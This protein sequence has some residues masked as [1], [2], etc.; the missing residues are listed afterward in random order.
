MPA[1]AHLVQQY[2]Q[3]FQ[4]SLT[5]I[6]AEAGAADPDGLGRQL[7]V[8]YEGATALATSCDDIQPVSDAKTAA[9]T[10]VRAALGPAPGR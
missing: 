10:L 2:K 8:L 6:A 9:A 3:A 5:R 7:A 1:V 4:H